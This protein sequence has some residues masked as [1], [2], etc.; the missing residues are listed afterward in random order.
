MNKH[1]VSVF[2]AIINNEIVAHETNLLSFHKIIAN[3]EPELFN[4]QAMRRKFLKADRFSLTI[5][6]KEYYF[7]KLV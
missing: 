4:Y 1:L 6:G 7:Q 3:K 5:G 2:T